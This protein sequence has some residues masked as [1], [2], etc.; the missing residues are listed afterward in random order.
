MKA[1]ACG[2]TAAGTVYYVR[3]LATA[4]A[5]CIM[6]VMAGLRSCWSA[7]WVQPHLPPKEPAQVAPNWAPWHPGSTKP[8]MTGRSVSF[9]GIL[10]TTHSK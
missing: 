10:K 6:A 8:W 7:F 3:F 2:V 5:C 1:V 9:T 4:G